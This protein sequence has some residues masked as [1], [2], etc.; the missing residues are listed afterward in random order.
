MI[1]TALALA[2]YLLGAIP[3]GVLIGLAR[4][5]DIRQHG[6]RN[7]GATNAG[8]VLGRRIG[9]LC[10]ALDILKGFVPAFVAMFFIIGDEPVTA[11]SL[12]TWLAIGAAA[13]VGHVFPVYLGFRGGKGVATT[14]GVALGVW[15]YYTFA[16]SAAL[17]AYAAAR[18]ATG[19]VSL[20]SI[21]LAVVFPLAAWGF[22]IIGRPGQL[23]TH[24]PLLA[25]AALLGVLILVRHRENIGRLLRGQ[26]LSLRSSAGRNPGEPT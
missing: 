21:A 13:V 19:I 9:L 4:G 22:V 17:L 5:V 20:G 11:S 16:M 10:L 23:D 7:T 6:S 8:R 15:P 24:W 12:T 3:F 26:E 14:I 25:V 1:P 2:S 18:Y